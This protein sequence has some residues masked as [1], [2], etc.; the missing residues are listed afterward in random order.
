MGKIILIGG[1]V[2]IGASLSAKEKKEFGPVKMVKMVRLEIFQRLIREAGGIDSRIEIITSASEIPRIIGKEY[3]KALEKL[4][5]RNIGIMHIKSAA[6]ADLHRHLDRLKKC[7]AILF[8]GG[9]Q[10]TLCDAFLN[11][12]FLEHLKERFK[13]EDRFLISGTSAGAM[14]L[15]KNTIIDGEPLT[16]FVKGHINIIDGFNLLPDIIIDSHFIQRRRLSR[17]IEAV[18][19]YPGKLGIGLAEDTAVFFNTADKVEVIGTNVVVLIDGRN[20]TYNNLRQ[21]KEKQNI[22]LLDVRLH[23]LPKGQMFSITRRKILKDKTS[24]N[25]S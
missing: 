4:K 18:A 21:I 6:G 3:K 7:D 10:N 13:K 19:K 20:I 12:K 9:N 22:C 1:N 23:V 17:L 2:D 8:T 24:K 15:A 5:C 25:R 11:T 16:P 14:S